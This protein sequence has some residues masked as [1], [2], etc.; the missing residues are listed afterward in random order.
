MFSGIDI[1]V[2]NTYKTYKINDECYLC[3]AEVTFNSSI[4]KVVIFIYAFSSNYSNQ[5]IKLSPN[6]SIGFYKDN[7]ASEPFAATLPLDN[8]TYTNEEG[9]VINLGNNSIYKLFDKT[10]PSYIFEYYVDGNYKT[11]GIRNNVYYSQGF[12]P[13]MKAPY[14]D[15]VEDLDNY[16]KSYKKYCSTINNDGEYDSD[17][18]C[19][20]ILKDPVNEDSPELTD[21]FVKR[22]GLRQEDR[23]IITNDMRDLRKDFFCAYEPCLINNPVMKYKLSSTCPNVEGICNDIQIIKNSNNVNL[24]IDTSCNV[25]TNKCDEDCDYYKGKICNEQT[26][27]CGIPCT[28]DEF[29]PSDQTCINGFCSNCISDNDCESGYRCY[30][31][32]CVKSCDSTNDCNVG[33]KNICWDNTCVQ[34]R[35]INDCPEGYDCFKN[36]CILKK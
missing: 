20:C 7:D 5:K 26:R 2:N 36:S 3:N 16:E 12:V 4:K 11:I 32:E 35:D 8:R 14:S 15:S 34:C 19:P 10:Y 18:R 31:Q 27:K 29:C 21:F 28:D 6:G 25:I 1:E 24:T 9:S 23:D 17:P 22:Y 30:N 33:F 13:Y